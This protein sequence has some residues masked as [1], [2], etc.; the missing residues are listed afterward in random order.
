[1]SAL[2][3][4]VLE[5]GEWAPDMPD[6][7]NTG[8][9]AKNVI[10]WPGAYKSFPSMSIQS[11]ALNARVQGGY[12]ARD[13]SANVYNFAG[14]T[15][16]LYQQ[17]A[18][19]VNYVDATRLAGGAYATSAEDWWEMVQ[20]GETVIATNF[21]DSPQ[22]ITLGGANFAALAGTPPKAR[23]IAVVRDFVVTG[24]VNY[25]GTSYPNRMYWSGINNSAD[26]T[27][28]AS[29]QCDIQDLQGD[30]GWIQKII[31]GEYGLVFQER[32]VWKMTYVGSPV[33]FQFDQIERNRGAYAPQGVIGW[34]NMV[35]FLADDGF[36]MIVG[37]S[38]AQPIGAG[39]VDKFFLN[40]L[41]T[42]YAYA[43]NA[44]ID[45]T[46]KLVMWAYPGSGATSATCNS[47]I[48][49]NWAVKRWSIVQG[50][51]MECFTRYAATGYTLEGLDAV[52]SNLD[53][54]TPSLDSRVW[55]G[56]AQSLAAFDSAHKLNTIS[57]TAMDATVDTGEVQLAPG[58][59]A[60]VMWARPITDGSAA[61]VTLRTRNR[62]A[63][64]G[65]YG[66][67]STQDATGICP[68]RSNARYHSAR[69]TTTGAFSFIQGVEVQFSPEGE[70]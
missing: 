39:K 48:I 56:G 6:L 12:F 17:V 23:H 66:T 33:I 2:Q 10:P 47:I 70:R 50:L 49:Y 65:T 13:A 9:T 27:I 8:I 68:M 3:R 36:Y 14:T 15:S 59:R 55:T 25:G 4:K 30:G 35:F 40:D 52:D 19:S 54:L 16:K 43:I 1:V 28:A 26:W 5:V 21:I 61:S 37:G 29:T 18:S 67:A 57:G 31:G 11:T 62:T 45:P 24:N 38:P 42:A 32:A 20:W 58:R 41:Q 44:A 51:S 22:V 64:S 69:T 7:G 60:S 53:T 46:N 63:D 34:G